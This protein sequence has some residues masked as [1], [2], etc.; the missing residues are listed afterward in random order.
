MTTDALADAREHAAEAHRRL[1]DQREKVVRLY[2]EYEGAMNE[3]MLLDDAYKESMDQY[4]RAL[5]YLKGQL[6]ADV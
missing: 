3:Y 2:S 6:E 4:A 5:E 1:V